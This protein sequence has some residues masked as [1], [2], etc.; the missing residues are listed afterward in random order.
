MK[1][2][3]TARI[4]NNV[5]VCT[6]EQVRVAE[7]PYICIQEVSGSNLALTNGYLPEAFPQCL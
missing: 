3:D 1:C 4:L 6:T 5:S 2:F 7:K